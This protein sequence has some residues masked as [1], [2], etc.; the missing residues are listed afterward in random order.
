MP[1][2][3]GRILIYTRHLDEMTRFYC[4]YFGF[5]AIRHDGDRIVELRPEGAGATILLH[6]AAQGQ[7]QGQALVKLVF[8][9][10][11]VEDFCR[12]AA[13][14][15]LTFGPIHKADGYAFANA[16]DPSGNTGSVSSRAYRD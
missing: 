8:D 6:P 2:A 11:D 4:E 1:A 13:L 12:R 15:G 3:L 10:E 7:K 9:L 5:R 16:N 14:G